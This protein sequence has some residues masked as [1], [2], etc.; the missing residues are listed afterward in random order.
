MTDKK[1]KAE[2]HEP[3]AHRDRGLAS[4]GPHKGQKPQPAASHD[5]DDARAEA[6]DTFRPDRDGTGL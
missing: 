6:D 5:P 2:E 1:A 4:E 3:H